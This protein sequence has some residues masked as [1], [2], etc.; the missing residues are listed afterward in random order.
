MMKFK[1]DWLLEAMDGQEAQM[2]QLFVGLEGGF[3]PCHYD[4]QD[5]IFAQV[6]GWKRVLLFHPKHFAS[7]YP[8]PVH[9][10]QDRQSRVNFDCPDY[11]RFPA[12]H[13]LEG[14]GLEALIGPGDILHI[15]S[16][17]WHHIEM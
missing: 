2:C 4:P 6:R 12:F 1:W 8:W 15:P 9:H 17:W 5:N 13:A 16:G 10:P 7:L 3:S 14:Q 11:E